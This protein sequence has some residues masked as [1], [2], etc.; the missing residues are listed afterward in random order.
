[1]IAGDLQGSGDGQ[2]NLEYLE[3][4]ISCILK[5]SETILPLTVV[6]TQSIMD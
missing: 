1:M 2:F 5:I 6:Y 3:L 4:R